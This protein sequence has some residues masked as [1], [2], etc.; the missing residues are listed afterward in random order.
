MARVQLFILALIV[1]I[2]GI[3]YLIYRLML[4]HEE[5]KERESE[6]EHERR[7]KREDRDFDSMMTMLESEDDERDR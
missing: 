1:V 5:R 3:T 4:K 2:L 6:R 7:L